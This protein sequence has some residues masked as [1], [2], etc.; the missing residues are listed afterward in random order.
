MRELRDDCT[1]VV[2]DTRETF[3]S[4]AIQIT[5][6]EGGRERKKRAA[7]KT[8]RDDVRRRSSR[9]DMKRVIPDTATP[10]GCSLS[11]MC[12]CYRG[13]RKYQCPARG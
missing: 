1:F 3:F 7:T 6:G 5:R 9:R 13:R 10:R 11:E 8:E 4:H 2:C 12:R